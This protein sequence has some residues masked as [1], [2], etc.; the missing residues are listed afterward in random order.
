MKYYKSPYLIVIEA[1]NWFNLQTSCKLTI[2]I[3]YIYIIII[4]LI[5]LI[6][7]HNEQ[8][9]SSQVN[10]GVK[11]YNSAYLIVIEATNWFN[12]QPLSGHT[13]S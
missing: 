3:I 9:K 7:E 12:Q 13:H 1:T 5:V 2:D 11:Y 8:T 6:V 4:T 10:I